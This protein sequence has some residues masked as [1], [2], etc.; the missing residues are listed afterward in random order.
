MF[1]QFQIKH[2][3]GFQ[4]FSIDDLKQI[5]L[6]SGKNN[7]GKTSLLEGLFIHCGQSNAEVITRVNLWRGLLPARID[8]AESA[9]YFL[10]PSFYN[11]DLSVPIQFKSVGETEKLRTSEI[12]A[13]I[14][15]TD[16]ET[17]L[18]RE[19]ETGIARPEGMSLKLGHIHYE[20]E[21]E[22]PADHDLV[23]SVRGSDIGV[24]VVPPHRPLS[25]NTHFLHEGLGPVPVQDA[26]IYSSLREA[27][28]EGLV[29]DGLRAVDP[30]I[31]NLEVL[32]PAGAP[33]LYVNLAS[34]KR[35]PLPLVGQGCARLTHILLIMIQAAGGVILIDEIAYGLHYNALPEVW[36]VISAAASQFNVQVFATTHSFE[37]IAAGHRAFA[38]LD[39]YDQFGY[40]RLEIADEK[41]KTI[42]V[43]R[44][45]L[46]L[47]IDTGF[48]IR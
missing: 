26:T 34:G 11:G 44:E 33:S 14:G 28:R 4:D 16:V 30:S 13:Q 19:Q 15:Q 25:F 46:S 21:G 24:N 45:S 5:T 42:C 31:K 1:K 29:L 47:A 32:S 37:V 18:P 17:I 39:R 43:D 38:D 40:Y 8:K 36:K 2:F 22:E 41:I 7:V 10:G 6:I 20:E 23:L 3:R 48:E 12:T 9:R 35:L 27:G